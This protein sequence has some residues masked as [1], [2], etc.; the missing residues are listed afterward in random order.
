MDPRTEEY[1]ISDDKALLDI[2]FVCAALAGSYWAPNRPRAVIEKSIQNSVCLGIYEKRTG[3]QVG[4]ARIV[5]DGATVAWLGDVIVDEAHRRKGLGKLLVSRVVELMEKNGTTCLLATRD[6]HGL[7]EKYGFARSELMKR[8]VS[9]AG[10][11]KNSG[12]THLG[13]LQ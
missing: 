10:G 6:A 11:A 13:S 7:Y 5:T 2:G 9:G 3:K 4:F 8:L 12:A 1:L